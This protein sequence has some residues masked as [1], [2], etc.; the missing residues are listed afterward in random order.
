MDKIIFSYGGMCNLDWLPYVQWNPTTKKWDI[1]KAFF[2]E[3]FRNIANFG[4]NSGP[5]STYCVGRDLSLTYGLQELCQPWV[6]T[7]NKCDL[8]T[9]NPDYFEAFF[10]LIKICN[11][12]NIMPIVNIINACD[13]NYPERYRWSPFNPLNNIQGIE[14]FYGI[15]A[16]IPIKQLVRHLLSEQKRLGAKIFWEIGKEIDNPTKIQEIGRLTEQAFM[17]LFVEYNIPGEQLSMGARTLPPDPVTQTK[18]RQLFT[19]YLGKPSDDLAFRPTHGIRKGQEVLDFAMSELS[20]FSILLSDDGA[21]RKGA[22]PEWW[23]QTLDFVF[24]HPKMSTPMVSKT[25]QAGVQRC[26]VSFEKFMTDEMDIPNIKEI[27]AGC[28]RRGFTFI[29]KGKYPSV[30]ECS[31]GETMKKICQDG[32]EVTTHICEN[33]KWVSTG[34]V[35]PTIP[36]NA[37]FDFSLDFRVPMTFDASKSTGNIVKYSWDFGDGWQPE[38]GNLAFAEGM[39]VNHVFRRPMTYNV[40]LTV[41]DAAGNTSTKLIYVEVVEE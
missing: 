6:V 11:T 36:L 21:N 3:F 17:P 30:I 8:M 39:I 35:C 20:D 40:L 27:I 9:L 5:F 38:V 7:N 37:D 23:K 22:T 24:S 32:S 14:K 13:F 28:E 1:D 19:K 18:I 25:S 34:N 31:T 29:N 33:G 41:Q 4:V 2:H 15:D 26:R 10:T 16:I 12:Y